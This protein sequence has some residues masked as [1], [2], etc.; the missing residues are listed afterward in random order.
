M[1][2][3]MG[4]WYGFHFIFQF[5]FFLIKFLPNISELG[6]DAI[7]CWT[8]THRHSPSFCF[9]WNRYANQKRNNSVRKSFQFNCESPFF[10]RGKLQNFIKFQNRDLVLGTKNGDENHFFFASNKRTTDIAM[11]GGITEFSKA[12]G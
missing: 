6:A 2:L 7:K 10:V 8:W 12:N 3:V 11:K 1:P 9:T 5:W 4:N